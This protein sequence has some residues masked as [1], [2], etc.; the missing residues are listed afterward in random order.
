MKE[1]LS[2]SQGC[3]H[4]VNWEQRARAGLAVSASEGTLPLRTLIV[5]NAMWATLWDSSEGNQICI[6]H[7]SD[8]SNSSDLNKAVKSQ[9]SHGINLPGEA[10]FKWE[11]VPGQQLPPRPGALQP[12]SNSLALWAAREQ[13][14][15]ERRG[16]EPWTRAQG[17]PRHRAAMCPGSDTVWLAQSAA[18][19]GVGTGAL[20]VF[21]GIH[22]SRSPNEMEKAASSDTQ[23]FQSGY[24]LK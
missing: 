4:R 6:P 10:N 8:S 20:S 2:I 17:M 5:S 11:R 16:A 1:T 19:L 3:M 18:K 13:P 24:R 12:A 22:N 7:G 14:Q 21:P 15:Q 23:L 9:I